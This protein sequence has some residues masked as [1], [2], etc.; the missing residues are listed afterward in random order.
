MVDSTLHF[1]SHWTEQVTLA[2]GRE[3]T[4][5][6]VRP[7][8]KDLFVEGLAR[9]SDESRY[10]RFFTHKTSLSTGELRYLTELDGERH[11][12]L[13]ALERDP[14]GATRGV[15][16]ARFVRLQDP[17]VAEPAVAVVDACQGKGLGKHL[18]LRLCA[19]A[20]ERGVHTFRAEVLPDNE[21]ILALLRSLSSDV[22]TR[23]KDDL[24]VVDMTL[25]EVALDHQPHEAPHG[26]VLYRLLSH[27]G[28]GATD[29]A[30]TLDRLRLQLIRGRHAGS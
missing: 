20:T 30:R 17:H 24:L 18:L 14:A 12:A 28:S 16:V 4:L 7:E 9:L 27:V 13:G 22:E 2:D 5:R 3:I 8:D 6:L 29:V 23:W 26:H 15:G 19:A 25:P 21:P 1:D 10:R 11:F